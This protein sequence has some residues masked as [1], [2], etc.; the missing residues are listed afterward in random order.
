MSQDVYEARFQRGPVG[1]LG[2][3]FRKRLTVDEDDLSAGVASGP[4]GA[5]DLSRRELGQFHAHQRDEP[6][7]P[8]SLGLAMQ[9]L[10]QRLG[11]VQG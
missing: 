2:H 4:S 7:V 9:P 5:R 3:V 11:V 8:P 6:L 1:S 10:H